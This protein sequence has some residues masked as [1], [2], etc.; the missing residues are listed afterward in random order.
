VSNYVST[1]LTLW[2]FECCIGVG[3]ARALISLSGWP[4]LAR[5]VLLSSSKTA[6]APSL[7]LRSG[8]ALRFV[9]GAGTMLPR[10]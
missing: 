5:P 2:Y 8:Q 1:T 10:A 7:R 6:G 3:E 4:V 9:Q